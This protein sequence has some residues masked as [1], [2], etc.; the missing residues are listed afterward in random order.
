MS[1]GLQEKGKKFLLYL[2]QNLRLVSILLNMPLKEKQSPHFTSL[3]GKNMPLNDWSKSEG[4][5]KETHTPGFLSKFKSS[6]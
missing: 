1:Y 3:P 6:V 2:S 5:K 4:Q